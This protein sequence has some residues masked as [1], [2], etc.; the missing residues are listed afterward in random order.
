MLLLLVTVVLLVTRGEGMPGRPGSILMLDIAT[1][2][3]MSV[4]LGNGKMVPMAHP[5]TGS[6][7]LFP[8]TE[9]KLPDGVTLET[10][11]DLPPEVRHKVRDPGLYIELRYLHSAGINPLDVSDFIDPQ[12]GRVLSSS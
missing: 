5:E 6:R 9:E 8:V 10:L 3:I 7:T 12:T 11:A 2:E 1:G 4:Q